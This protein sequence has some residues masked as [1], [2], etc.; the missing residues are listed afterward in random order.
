MNRSPV[1]PAAAIL[2]AVVLAACATTS[3]VSSS[4]YLSA[5]DLAQTDHETVYQ[6][7]KSHGKVGFTVVSGREL[8]YIDDRGFMSLT[9]G[10]DARGS[11]G[12]MRQGRLE[13]LLIVNEQEVGDP[14]PFLR[15]MQV[16]SVKRLQILRPQETSAR[17][18]GDGRQGAV[19]VF[20]QGE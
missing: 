4:R 15:D 11:Q 12:A 20:T 14:V 19:V 17:Y 6:L 1:V 18:G 10:S 5:E 3:G 13:A 2:V 16:S 8:M 9:Q 7:L